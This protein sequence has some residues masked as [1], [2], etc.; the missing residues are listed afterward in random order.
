MIQIAHPGLPTQGRLFA[1]PCP[2]P[3]AAAAAALVAEGITTAACLLGPAGMVPLEA[4]YARTPL[5]VLRFPIADFGVPTD[6]VA[7][8]AFLQVLLERLGA[9]ESI[10]LHCQGGIGRTGTALACLFILA[11]E[12]PATAIATVRARYRPDAVETSAQR[13]FVEA[14]R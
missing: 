4:A 7:F 9:G 3:P 11:G 12:S 2:D 13:R 5:N 14:F 10:Y 8:R 6:A 1:G